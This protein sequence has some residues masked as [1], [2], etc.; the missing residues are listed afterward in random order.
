MN[1]EI[2][3]TEDKITK[4]PPHKHAHWEI[5][6]YLHGNGA[7]YTPEKQYPFQAGTMILVPPNLIHGSVSENGFKNISIGGAF[8]NSI[9][10]RT[11]ISIRDDINHTGVSIAKI[12]Y[13]NRFA[14]NTLIESLCSSLVCFFTENRK[15][16]TSAYSAVC[17]CINKMNA[18][19]FDAE[20]SLP[21]ILNASGYA[22]DYIRAKFKEYTGKTPTKFLTEIRIKKAK[23]LIEI[24]GQT[25][26]LQEIMLKCGFYDYSYFS[27]K[28]KQYCGISP[29]EYVRRCSVCAEQA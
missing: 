11:P 28:F 6:V 25:V 4:Y 21:R 14:S 27:K 2:N 19:A 9:F 10:G 29:R 22:E 23:F 12:I 13:Q 24:Y 3:I 26:L 17:A 16:E 15:L 5:M 7:L 8:D 1:M 20:L 18:G